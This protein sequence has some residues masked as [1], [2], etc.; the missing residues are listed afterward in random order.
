MELSGD[1]TAIACVAIQVYDHYTISP[2]PAICPAGENGGYLGLHLTGLD[3]TEQLE[4]L[5]W[6]GIIILLMQN[7]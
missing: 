5:L 2:M 7:Y 6:K 1:R 4:N 3:W